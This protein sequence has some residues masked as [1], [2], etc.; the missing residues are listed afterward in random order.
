MIVYEFNMGDVE[1][2]EIYCASPLYDWQQSEHGKWVMNNSLEKPVFYIRPGDHYGYK[3]IVTA[4][5]NT[6]DEVWYNL[7]FK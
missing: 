1:D 2:P 7:K 4:K 5:F 3:V 6:K